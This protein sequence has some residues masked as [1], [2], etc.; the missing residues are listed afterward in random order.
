MFGAGGGGTRWAA[1]ASQPALQAV[2]K[3]Y[4]DKPYVDKLI[5]SALD[6]IEA[7]ALQLMQ[8]QRVPKDE[9]SVC[10]VQ[11]AQS[12]II[13]A[14]KAGDAAHTAC[15]WSVGPVQQKKRQIVWMKTVAGLPWRIMCDRCMV[16][17]RMACKLLH[18]EE[19]DDSQS[20]LVENRQLST[21]TLSHPHHQSE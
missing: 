17:E 3:S 4:V 1:P 7:Q 20:E 8:L 11:N 2:D 6:K 5:Q 9:R 12:H 15:G 21:Y 16:P 14:M 19:G 18:P 10:Y 13:H